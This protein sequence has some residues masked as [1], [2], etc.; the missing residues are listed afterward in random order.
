MDFWKVLRKSYNL[1]K[2]Y[3]LLNLLHTLTKR[4]YY[5]RMTLINM[6][7]EI[8]RSHRMV[9]G[10]KR[11]ELLTGTKYQESYPRDHINIS[12]YQQI[13]LFSVALLSDP[14]RP[15]AVIKLPQKN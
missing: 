10:L 6:A 13:N 7:P 1:S 5:W 2:P 9:D 4:W 14:L 12:A 8:V 11:E 3:N 15:S